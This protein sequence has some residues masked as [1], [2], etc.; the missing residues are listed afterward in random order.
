MIKAGYQ[1]IVESYEGD[2]NHYNT[3][4]ISGLTLDE[5]KFYI[6]LVQEFYSSGGESGFGNNRPSSE[7]YREVLVP[8]INAH[9]CAERYLAVE[10]A[11]Y[12][13]DYVIEAIVH[14]LIGVSYESDVNRAY[15]G[16][17]VYY[18]EKGVSEVNL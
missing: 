8:I 13:A 1:L 18:F 6:A 9:K 16:H 2:A 17:T 11:E 15:G 3:K 7:E 14:E 4:S 5:V 12:V 10:D